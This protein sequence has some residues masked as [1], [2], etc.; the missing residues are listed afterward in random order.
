MSARLEA[1]NG[2]LRAYIHEL[3]KALH[4]AIAIAKEF[5]ARY[6]AELKRRV[7]AECLLAKAKAVVQ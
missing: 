3:T 7:V 6:D 2:E 5:D 1:E 4:D